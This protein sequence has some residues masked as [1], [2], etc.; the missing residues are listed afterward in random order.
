MGL[1]VTQRV[2]LFFWRFSSHDWCQGIAGRWLGKPII[3]LIEAMDHE[4]PVV[5]GEGARGDEF[6]WDFLVEHQVGVRVD[7]CILSSC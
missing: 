5:M 1:R 7:H 3:E 4:K 2:S 6:W